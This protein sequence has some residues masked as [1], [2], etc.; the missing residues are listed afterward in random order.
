[1][2]ASKQSR[3]KS[4]MHASGHGE[5]Y[6]H[7][8]KAIAEEAEAIAMKYFRADELLVERKHDGT[9]VTQADRAV[10]AMAR[11]K[12]ATSGLALDVLGEEMGGAD[13]K[14]A[15]A[16]GRARLIIDPIDGTEEFSRGI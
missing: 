11:E 12:V 5:K 10:E 7:L 6:G 13:P 9:A 4:T 16:S 14:A 15:S 2:E 1:M 3:V 8:L